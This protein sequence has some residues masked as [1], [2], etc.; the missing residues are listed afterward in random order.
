MAVSGKGRL[1]PVAAL[2]LGL[3]A[4]GGASAQGLLDGGG[5][6][7]KGFGGLTVPQDDDFNVNERG[8]GASGD[9]GF[10]FDNGYVLGI[11]GGYMVTPNVAVE[12]EYAY[13]NADAEL[14]NT[15]GNS[16]KTE[17]NAFMVNALYN[18]TPMGATGAWQ[19]Y[20]GG[21]LGAADLNFE[22]VPGIAGATST[23]TTTSPI[24]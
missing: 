7:L 14:K 15:D 8:T 16:R 18:F 22:Q 23:A 21:G 12:L 10:D 13:R 5:F 1:A 17:S 3:G 6:Y 24:S 9:S 4:A 20:A 11:A 2:A 19:P